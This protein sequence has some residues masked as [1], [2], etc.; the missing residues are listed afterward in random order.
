VRKQI[1][2]A[3]PTLIILG[4]AGVVA[5]QPPGSH[6]ERGESDSAP[7]PAGTV[8]RWSGNFAAKAIL[9]FI[10]AGAGNEDPPED[11]ARMEATTRTAST[12]RVESGY[13]PVNGLRIYYEIR[14]AGPPLVLLHGGGSTIGT[15]FGKVLEPLAEHRRVIAFEQQGHGRTADVDRPFSFEQSADDAAALLKHL[16]IERADFYGYSNGGSIAMQMGI[17][18]PGLVRKLVVA[19]AMFRNDGL[20]PGFKESLKGATPEDMPASLRDAYLEVAPHPEALPAFVAK[21]T[22]P[23]AGVRGLARRAHPVDRRPHAG[24]DRRRRHHPP[25][26][27]RG[28]VPPAPPSAARNPPRDGPHGAR[29]PR[30][31]A[32]AD[33]PRIPRRPDAGHRE[34]GNQMSTHEREGAANDREVLIA[35]TFDAPRDLVFRAWIEPDHLARWYA[36]KGC[37]VIIHEFD[38]R[39]GGVFHHA[40]QTPGGRNCLCKGVY[41]E[42]VPPERLVYTLSFSDAAG[43]FVEPADVGADPEWPRET[44]VTVTFDDLG[45]KTKLTLHQTVLE[46][47]AKR[48]GAHPSWIEMLDRLAELATNP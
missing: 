34:N 40:I 36:P 21:C 22:A 9:S 16:G 46:S 38:P 13:T 6:I 17:R 35:R 41:R 42:I 7:D 18:H 39:P 8:S 4:I 3:T 47:I 25:R 12:G 26:A 23:D 43:N 28:D 45:G 24:P 30:R 10:V 31:P 1:F 15:S 11:Q 32:A 29:R 33:P 20:P 48:T 27:C 2:I 5:V 19:S 37:S 14:G 44:V